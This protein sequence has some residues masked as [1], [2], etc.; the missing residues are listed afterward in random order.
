MKGK[1]KRLIELTNKEIMELKEEGI[2][3]LIDLECA[4]LGIK[5]SERPEEI[6]TPKIE[7]DIEAFQ[8]GDMYFKTE[9]EAQRVYDAIKSTKV[10]RQDYNYETGDEW[11]YLNESHTFG[12]DLML[13]KAGFLSEKKLETYANEL[14]KYKAKKEDF[15][16]KLSDWRGE[17]EKRGKVENKVMNY[18]DGIWEKENEKK[19]MLKQYKKYLKL[20]GE[21]KEIA[22]KFLCDA[23]GTEHVR[24]TLGEEY[25]I[26]SDPR[27]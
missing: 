11:K 12:G 23:Y 15:D 3:D 14:K 26:L 17:E 9:E 4:V 7:N 20:A 22:K 16:K 2:Q 6:E 18:I 10:F 5:I 21:D 25:A 24:E 1:Y 8:I 27:D 13:T 19:R